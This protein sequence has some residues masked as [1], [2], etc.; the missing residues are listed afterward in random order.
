MTMN[1]PLANVLSAIMNRERIASDKIV[2][3]PYSKSIERILNIMKDYGYIGDIKKVEDGRGGLFE[4]NLIGKLNKC[5]VIKPRFAFNKKTYDKFEKR[6]LPAKNFGIIIVST[7]EGF[8]TIDQA[9]KKGLGGR[10][11]AYCY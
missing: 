5:N 9:R 8:T 3:G 7:V 2:V 10:L 11:I 1:D 6:F 4:I